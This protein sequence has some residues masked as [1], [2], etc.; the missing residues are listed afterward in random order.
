MT[1]ATSAATENEPIELGGFAPAIAPAGD[2]ATHKQFELTEDYSST[3]AAI[4]LQLYGG[5]NSGEAQNALDK[6]R[7]SASNALL[8]GQD[9]EQ[10][11]DYNV[12]D[13]TSGQPLVQSLELPKY[14][15]ETRWEFACRGSYI[16]HPEGGGPDEAGDAYNPRGGNSNGNS[17]L[18]SNS[19]FITIAGEEGAPVD[20]IDPPPTACPDGTHD[21]GTGNCVPDEPTGPQPCAAGY[22][23]D[24]TGKCIPDP[25]DPTEPKSCAANF[26]DNGE[27]V[28]VPDPTDPSEPPTC[29][30]GK[31]WNGVA[32]VPEPTDPGEPKTCADGFRLYAGAC[33]PDVPEACPAL[34][35]RWIC[36]DDVCTQI[37]TT[38]AAI[39]YAT[40]AACEADCGGET[41]PPEPPIDP[42]LAAP[43]APVVTRDCESGALVVTAPAFPTNATKLEMQRDDAAGIIHLFAGAGDWSDAATT[44]A[45]PY[46][47]RCRSVSA[48]DKRSDWGAYSVAKSRISEA[49]TIEWLWPAADE[50]LGPDTILRFKLTDTGETLNE[51]ELPQLPPGA[52]ASLDVNDAQISLALSGFALDIAVQLVDGTPRNGTYEALLDARDYSGGARDLI[53]RA[54]GSDCC[55]ASASRAVALTNTLQGGVF[56][57]EWQLDWPT[58]GELIAQV[59]LGFENRALE[60]NPL[61]RYW[62][63]TGT[64][65][66]TEL[67]AAPA[68]GYLDEDWEQHYPV[69]WRGGRAMTAQGQ[70]I[71]RRNYSATATLVPPSA[72]A[73][74]R[75]KW[76]PEY[77]IA[78]W[79]TGCAQVVKIRELEAGKHLVFGTAP[80]KAFFYEN[81]V[82]SLQSDL[83]AAVFDAADAF[84]A[85]AV[86]DKIYIAT[87]DDVFA[88]D[89]DAGQL[90]INS[91]IRRAPGACRFLEAVGGQP[92]AFY[93]N[94]EIGVD[95]THVY[96][97]DF[98]SPLPLWTLPEAATAT[99]EDA[100]TLMV[101][102]G[103]KLYVAQGVA[104]PVL[105]HEFDS[106]V[107]SVARHDERLIV[108]LQSGAVW[109]GAGAN[110]SQ[111]LQLEGAAL[112]AAIWS[113]GTVG[114]VNEAPARAIVGGAGAWLS[115]ER[116]NG[117]W[118]D[119]RELIV[120]LDLLPVEVESVRALGAF[121]VETEAA[122]TEAGVPVQAAQ[123]DERILAGTQGRDGENEGLFFVYQRSVLDSD[124]G[125]I[126]ASRDAVQRIVVS[127]I[128]PDTAEV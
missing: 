12:L 77:A 2:T 86:A 75:E 48:D 87:P 91:G 100:G 8:Q 122:K 89:L 93:V 69:V 78:A 123:R 107:T 76:T 54:R 39:G 105:A 42:T 35:T 108:G 104:A 80:A 61:R 109:S 59:S 125:A 3:Y 112:G 106:P 19:T 49:L 121:S 33:V 50:V 103:V 62:V 111:V 41:G 51:C 47:Y 21:D 25:V 32:C 24:G 28:C 120:P 84:D 95:S 58:Q 52:C 65:S 113:G 114:E 92:L 23:D 90:P 67:D 1:V 57:R 127:A 124:K 88:V 31:Y 36:V 27:G 45:T 96:N 66:G 13:Y 44:E 53:V 11:L 17:P 74:A 85:C 116:E 20:P 38:D 37:Q 7:V 117:G 34:F 68:R 119:E 15:S 72:H 102:C 71:E 5:P 126:L 46:R 56:C 9:F 43:A 97:L 10:V 82:L 115:G 14:A 81:D 29:A 101:A 118:F 70:R 4:N 98:P 99:W 16:I 60:E 94:D 110:W 55:F 79:Q 128:V 6:R 30:T 22:H 64:R 18:Y 26:H 83:G 73:R 63:Q 40:Q